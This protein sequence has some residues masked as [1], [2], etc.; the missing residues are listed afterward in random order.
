MTRR[1]IGFVFSLLGALGG[2]AAATAGQ[3]E[4]PVP[5]VQLGAEMS[6]GS[7]GGG[8]QTSARVF[9]PRFTVNFSPRW[10]L[11]ATVDRYHRPG[12]FG[13][14]DE[15]IVLVQ[16]R[17]RLAEFSNGLRLSGLLGGGMDY[18]RYEFPSYEGRSFEPDTY[19]QPRTY[20]AESLSH[21][22]PLI[23]TG[24]GLS[25]AITPHLAVHSEVKFF[26]FQRFGFGARA[27][28]GMT[29]AVGRFPPQ[30]KEI[31]LPFTSSRSVR[32][33][34]R[35]WVTT[36]DGV[37]ITGAV[38]SASLSS[39]TIA[40]GSGRE[41]IPVASLARIDVAESS[42][43]ARNR[44][45]VVGGLGGL[46]LGVAVTVSWVASNGGEGA[47]AFGIWGPGLATLG[48]VAGGLIGAEI[49]RRR[50]VRHTIYD[51]GRPAAALTL[52]PLVTRRAH[53]LSATI[54]W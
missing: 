23:L 37:Q 25:R 3:S 27:T 26:P 1:F 41:T 19:G 18:T 40:R 17:T 42:T 20:P 5:R 7:V 10:A 36:T 45:M 29:A 21:R 54:R 46:G 16:L 15:R 32:G 39:L 47:D 35:V 14:L 43:A 52:T 48:I 2:P 24:L 30:S 51:V 28:L 31:A 12:Q 38:I 53:G 13:E 50:A 49:D 4:L 33:G 8:S 44:W 22:R 9:V 11:D 6:F 34:Q